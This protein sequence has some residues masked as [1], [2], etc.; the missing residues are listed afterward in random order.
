MN[1]PLYGDEY[2]KILSNLATLKVEALNMPN[3]TVQISAGGFW[4]YTIDG[5]KY[6]EFPGGYSPIITAPSSG[7][8]W[9]IVAITESGMI[10]N[11]D[12]TNIDLPGIPRYRTPL[13]AIYVQST[14]Q[15]ITNDMI[16]DIR[17][18][19]DMIIRF[20]DDLSGRDEA[21]CHSI[22]AIVGLTELLET[23]VN[24]E[25]FHLN[26]DEKADVDGTTSTT[27]TLNKD[28]TGT[29][30]SNVLIEVERGDENNV[31]IQWNETAKSWQ[32]T[33]DGIDWYNLSGTLV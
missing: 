31:S 2:R 29:P 17:P 26:L 11:L 24:E 20:H 18:L 23:L 28:Q 27:F 1:N 33:N 4:R 12:G 7:A 19:F 22:A 5:S 25:T 32:F 14:T 8:K 3:M 15:K 6:I 16:C 10:I 21:G 13:A 30:S 9:V